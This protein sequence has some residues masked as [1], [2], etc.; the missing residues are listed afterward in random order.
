MIALI[1]KLNDTL[2]LTEQI[3]LIEHH[4]ESFI[5][6]LLS[7]DESFDGGE[8]QYVFNENGKQIILTIFKDNEA[9]VK[10]E[11]IVTSI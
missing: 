1:N 2:T 10:I 3:A 11:N 4:K 8:N 6:L 5:P 9:I 7:G